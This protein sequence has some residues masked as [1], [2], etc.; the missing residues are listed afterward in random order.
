MPAVERA[1]GKTLP[2]LVGLSERLNGRALD[3]EHWVLGSLDGGT[4][5]GG[6]GQGAVMSGP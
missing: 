2:E 5:F 6:A 1:D 3:D 4:A